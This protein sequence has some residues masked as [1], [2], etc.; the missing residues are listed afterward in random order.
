M[1]R[2]GNFREAQSLAKVWNRKIKKNVKT[3]E[4]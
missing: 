2:E 1:A 3:E 4:D